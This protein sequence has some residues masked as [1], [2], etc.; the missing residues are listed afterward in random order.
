MTTYKDI[1]GTKVEVRDDD[2]ANPV[3]GQVWYNSGT[4]KGFKLNP[5]GAWATG[6]NL[7]LGREQNTGLSVGTQT[8]GLLFGGDNPTPGG[9]VK[10]EEYNGSSWTESGNMNTSRRAGAG[11]GSQTSAMSGASFAGNTG[12]TVKTETYNG[13]T[14]TEIGDL[15]VDRAY[16]AGSGTA[17]DEGI[18]FGGNDGTNN[19]AIT[20]SYNGSAWAEV[21]DCLL[22]TSPS[23]RDKRQSR[24]PSSA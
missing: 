21:G 2:P 7:N 22:Y 15:N 9:T 23:P 18:L 4:L 24:M 14:W 6:G 10:T 1:H 19:I 3:N 12:E 17:N 20:E 16:G 5:T 13:S 11:Y 8:A